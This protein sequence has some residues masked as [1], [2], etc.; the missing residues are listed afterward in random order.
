MSEDV[1]WE[2]LEKEAMK[3]VYQELVM[4][5]VSGPQVN[6]AKFVLELAAKYVWAEK[7]TAEQVV[8]NIQNRVNPPS[9]QAPYPPPGNFSPSVTLVDGVLVPGVPVEDKK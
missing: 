9:V 3:L 1:K 2:D 4:G 7:M 8:Q 6:M 5:D